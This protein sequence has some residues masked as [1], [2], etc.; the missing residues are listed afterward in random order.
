MAR[1]DSKDSVNLIKLLGNLVEDL[2]ASIEK[3]LSIKR[4]NDEKKDS[5]LNP[6]RYTNK[7]S[8]VIKKGQ[9]NLINS[10]VTNVAQSFSLNF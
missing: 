8:V 7:Q 10:F 6:N 2:N 3:G 9:E 5:R 4:E 1:L